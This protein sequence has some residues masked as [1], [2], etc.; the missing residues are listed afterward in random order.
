M[1]KK[2]RDEKLVLDDVRGLGRRPARAVPGGDVRDLHA[3][4]RRDLVPR[5]AGNDV[6]AVERDRL[7]EL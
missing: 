5:G 1:K 3:S 6:A 4:F 2:T 7:R